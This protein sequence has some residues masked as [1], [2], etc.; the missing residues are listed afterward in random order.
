MSFNIIR[1]AT[2][3]IILGMPQLEK[4]NLVINQKRKVLKFKR[5]SNIARFYPIY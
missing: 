4:Y 3:Y 2:Y 1:I 5:T